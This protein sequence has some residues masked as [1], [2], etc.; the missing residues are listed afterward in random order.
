MDVPPTLTADECLAYLQLFK[1]EQDWLEKHGAW[2][3]T[4]VGLGAGCLGTLVAYFLKSRCRKIKLC[5]LECDR[6]VVEL[7]PK[8][9]EAVSHAS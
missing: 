6:D 9:V 5:G 1:G 2:M 7:T 3:L 4:V 8:D